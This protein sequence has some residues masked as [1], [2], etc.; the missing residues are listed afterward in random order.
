M[1]YQGEVSVAHMNLGLD[2]GIAQRM[3]PSCW[4]YRSRTLIY[5]DSESGKSA[6]IRVQISV[7]LVD[8]TDF[9]TLLPV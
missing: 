2:Q 6:S 3:A 4:I 1:P 5:A 8:Y 9:A 7:W